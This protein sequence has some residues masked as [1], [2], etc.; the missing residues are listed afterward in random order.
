MKQSPKGYGLK[1]LD[2][3]IKVKI[4]KVLIRVHCRVHQVLQL[5][6]KW[7]NKKGQNKEVSGR[8]INV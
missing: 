7:E 8:F 4:G 3:F 6:Y 2:K 1:E 5:L